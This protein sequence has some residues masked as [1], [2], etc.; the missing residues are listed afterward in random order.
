M[1]DRVRLRVARFLSR[2]LLGAC[3]LSALP[4][5]LRDTQA[6]A[7]DLQQPLKHCRGSTEARIH[8]TWPT[9][10]DLQA[11]ALLP[12]GARLPPRV[13]RWLYLIVPFSRVA[14]VDP[15]IVA[16]VMQV[17]SH[18]DPLAWNLDSDAHGLMQ[19]LHASWEPAANVQLGVSMLAGFQRQFGSRDLTVAAYNAGPGSVQTYGGIPP[20][21]ETRDYVVMVDY[22][23]DL[24][25]GIKL[26]QV[27]VARFKAANA[28]LVAYYRRICG[29]PKSARMTPPS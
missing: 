21:T 8:I 20:F 10:S 28:D 3:L 23:R 9:R 14:G 22:Y 26:S 15:Y 7:T 24:F 4:L 13:R 27:R 1:T 11:D 2:V 6:L 17:E 12:W 19:V 29:K 5:C 18:G 25:A 16:G